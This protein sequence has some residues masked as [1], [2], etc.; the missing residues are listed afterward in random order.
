MTTDYFLDL[1][2]ISEEIMESQEFIV[3]LT[4]VHCFLFPSFF[5][6]FT[7]VL[8]DLAKKPKT[9]FLKTPNLGLSW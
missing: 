5:A 1:T 7:N 6:C 9:N 4:C 3:S 8:P 2:V